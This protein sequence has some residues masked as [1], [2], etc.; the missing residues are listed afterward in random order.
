MME[1]ILTPA[2]IFLRMPR[3]P[4][5]DEQPPWLPSSYREIAKQ[6]Y[7]PQCKC[8][9]KDV[10]WDDI[11][12]HHRNADRDDNHPKNLLPTC[13]SCHSKIHWGKGD[14]SHKRYWTELPSDSQLGVATRTV[15]REIKYGQTKTYGQAFDK[16]NTLREH[17]GQEPLE[18]W[19]FEE[20]VSKLILRLASE[21]RLTAP[22]FYEIQISDAVSIENDWKQTRLKIQV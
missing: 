17:R 1:R 22:S 12:I 3:M 13:E 19:E 14:H 7:T 15:S 18:E 11:E 5:R 16:V 8:C 20:L 4:D 6:Y 9:L 10:G 21:E 2:Y